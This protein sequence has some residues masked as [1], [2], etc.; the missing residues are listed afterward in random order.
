MR[1][2]EVAM[3]KLNK[4]EEQRL[5]STENILACALDLFV[6]NGYRTT[7]IDVI[8]AKAGLT[9]G[10]IYFYFRTKE[11]IMLKLLE[12]AEEYVVSPIEEHLAAAGP[13]AD[14]KLVK[15]IHSQSHLG[16][17]RPK[18]ILLLILVS[19]EFCGSGSEIE[20][21]IK[22]IYRRMY[23][24]IEQI[25]EQGQQAGIFRSDLGS[26]EL[27]AIV[28]AGH[29]GVLI[30]WYRRPQELKGRSL[31]TALR[32]TLLNGLLHTN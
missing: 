4:K 18:H 19:I 27:T 1:Y 12:Q 22:D 17:T 25:I 21:R 8:A 28:M 14:D 31:A 13:N 6:K 30:E 20:K 26:H 3:K 23:A 11:A 7:T 2:R 10:A 29:D 9:K 15:F 32:T 16:V 5:A 24:Y